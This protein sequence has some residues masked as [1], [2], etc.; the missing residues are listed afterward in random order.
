MNLNDFMKIVGEGI[1]YFRKKRG[2]SQEQLADMANINE[3]YLGK[4]ERAEKVCSIEKLFV[5]TNALNVPLHDFFSYIQ[6]E[7][8][9]SEQNLMQEI[10]NKLRDRTVDEQI[11]VI[12]MI[13]VL[14]DN[15]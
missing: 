10:V 12:K 1:R 11:K 4:L 5:I 2:L 3:S 9:N 15:S 14:F 13:D 7:G 8:M 6:P